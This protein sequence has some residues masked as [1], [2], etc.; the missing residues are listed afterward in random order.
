M[1]EM[2]KTID[3]HKRLQI[4]PSDEVINQQKVFNARGL[5]CSLA[6]KNTH[7]SLT[8]IE[9]LYSVKNNNTKSFHWSI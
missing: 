3:N 2:Q 5:P 6:D 7:I 8:F 1:P 9:R 4:T